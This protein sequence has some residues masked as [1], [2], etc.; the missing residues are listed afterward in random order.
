MKNA[1]GSGV[2][3]S[4]SHVW[5]NVRWLLLVVA[6]LYIAAVIWNIQWPAS[7][8]KTDAA[9]AA[10]HAQRLTMADADGKHLPPAPDPRLVDATVEGIDANSNGIR[11]DVE[12]AIYKKYPNSP[13]TRT[14]ELQY[15]KALQKYLV[16]V[17]NSETWIAAAI[18]DSRAY[19]CIS[20]SYPRTNL[21]LHGHVVDQRSKE[22]E[23][24]VF[25]NTDRKNTKLNADSYITSVALPDN[26]F[27]DFDAGSIV[28]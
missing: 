18:E 11:D 16:S 20:E 15:A 7:K 23:D 26:D 24:M 10:I 14:A 19:T 13:Y 6:L 1:E 8:E 3:M 5:K 12:L 22:V 2:N 27:C 17:F 4:L 25:N 9:V 21:S 28:I